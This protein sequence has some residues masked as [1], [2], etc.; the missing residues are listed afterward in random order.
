MYGRASLQSPSYAEL[1][2]GLGI[3]ALSIDHWGFGERRGRSESE[4][5]KEMLWHGR[6]LWGHMVYDSVRALDYLESRGD[7][8]SERIGTLGLSMGSTMAWWISALDP[9]LR[10]CVDICCLTDYDALIETH[11][12]DRH[13]LYYYAPRLLCEFSTADINALIAPRPHLSLAGDYDPLTLPAGLERIDAQLQA[14]YREAG[15]SEAWRLFRSPSAHLETA[16]M[17]TEIIQF[18]EEW[19]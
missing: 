1:L 12:L 17:R 15:A 3:A 5:F 4:I 8:D 14:I 2:A 18:L 7:V 9:R 16:A 11:G 19:L 6:V 13:G 10:L